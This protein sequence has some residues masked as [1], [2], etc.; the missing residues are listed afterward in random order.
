VT[1]TVQLYA[2]RVLEHPRI[3]APVTLH[4]ICSLVCWRVAE[5][6]AANADRGAAANLL[7]TTHPLKGATDYNT[8]GVKNY[9]SLSQGVWATVLTLT[10]GH[11]G[12]ILDSLR[13]DDPAPSTLARV[14]Q[15]PWGTQIRDNSAAAI[16]AFC[17]AVYHRWG[18]EAFAIVKGT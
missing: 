7:N 10:N 1:A 9:Q 14:V 3:D 18:A 15:S 4:T 13:H 12:A 16:T 2:K 8:V 5:C 17:V 11:Y 6:S